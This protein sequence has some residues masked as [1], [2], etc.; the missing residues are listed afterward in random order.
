MMTHGLTMTLVKSYT[1]LYTHC[2][3][4]GERAAVED[5]DGDASYDVDGVGAVDAPGGGRQAA[6][7]GAGAGVWAGDVLQ[8]DGEGRAAQCQHREGV[9]VSCARHG[10]EGTRQGHR[11]TGGYGSGTGHLV[12]FTCCNVACCA[13][14]CQQYYYGCYCIFTCCTI[15]VLM[16]ENTYCY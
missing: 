11:Q 7:R 13:N 6:A 14:I 16:C 3:S 5:Q 2:F 15:D 4:T 12:K 8:E 1:F 9:A 10:V